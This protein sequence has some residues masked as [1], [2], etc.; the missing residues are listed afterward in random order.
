MKGENEIFEN[1]IENNEMATLVRSISK[2]IYYFI[3]VPYLI[4]ISLKETN[5]Y[6]KYYQETILK[7][8]FS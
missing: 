6:M 1:L 4:W 8:V 5:K 7:G 2:H 3:W